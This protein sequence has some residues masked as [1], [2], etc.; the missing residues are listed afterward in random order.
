M[1]W[2]WKYWVR[3]SVCVCVCVCVCVF[4]RERHFRQIDRQREKLR[5]ILVDVVCE[6]DCGITMKIRTL[7]PGILIQNKCISN[8]LN[9]Q[10][11]Y[12]YA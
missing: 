2:K 7:H 8:F 10:Q 5:I 4:E 11:I 12:F 3:E 9:L 6:Y 1:G